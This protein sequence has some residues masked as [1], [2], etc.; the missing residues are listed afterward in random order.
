M[1]NKFYL[2][3]RTFTP[4][5]TRPTTT[6]TGNPSRNPGITRPR[7]TIRTATRALCA[8]PDWRQTLLS[9]DCAGLGLRPKLR[10]TVR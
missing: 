4:T 7:T 8:G 2:K 10:S 6:R 3:C 1:P 5:T 9:P